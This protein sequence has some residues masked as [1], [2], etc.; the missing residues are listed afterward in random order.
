MENLNAVI[1][2]I[3]SFEAF[4]VSLASRVGTG[5]LAGGHFH[6]GGKRRKLFCCSYTPLLCIYRH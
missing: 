4:A 3:S 6:P 2:A 1:T 5:N